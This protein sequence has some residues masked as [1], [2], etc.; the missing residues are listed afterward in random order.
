MNGARYDKE[1]DSSES[2]NYVLCWLATS[3]LDG[4]PSVSPKQIFSMQGS[5]LLLIANIASPQSA[6]NIRS[7][8]KVCVSMIDILV[9]KGVQMYGHATVVQRS[10]D[11]EF[12]QL[13]A[14]LIELTQGKF[15]FSTLFKVNIERV[16]EILAPSYRLFPETQEADQVA[17]A[18]QVY[19]LLD[20]Q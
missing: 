19:R 14:P 17:E 20:S 13:A 12:D 3:S 4:L 2:R 11:T 15:P 16:N 10:S 8:P 5:D 6:A 18:R 7:N 9:Q 1:M